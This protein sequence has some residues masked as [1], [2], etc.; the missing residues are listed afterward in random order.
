[1]QGSYSKV[2]PYWTSENTYCHL[3]FNHKV[4]GNQASLV[5]LITEIFTVSTRETPGLH[6]YTMSGYWVQWRYDYLL[7]ER[8][9]PGKYTLDCALNWS[10]TQQS[11]HDSLH[12]IGMGEK[13]TELLANEK[14]YTFLKSSYFKMSHRIGH[15]IHNGKMNI[16]WMIHHYGMCRCLLVAWVI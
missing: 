7:R 10:T 4:M 9:I 2:N 11:Q 16:S 1:M 3:L 6:T 12:V 15:I 13:W 14:N 5:P 8:Y